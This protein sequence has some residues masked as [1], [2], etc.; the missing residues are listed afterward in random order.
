MPQPQEVEEWFDVRDNISLL[1][2]T[3]CFELFAKHARKP[4]DLRCEFWML[5]TSKQKRVHCYSQKDCIG[6]LEKRWAEVDEINFYQ[7]AGPLRYAQIAGRRHYF[8]FRAEEL[9]FEEIER[10]FTSTF[11]LDQSRPQPYKYRSSSIEFDIGHWSPRLF[12][13]GLSKI[14]ELVGPHP[15]LERA[16]YKT[17]EGDIEKLTPF[18]DIDE[19]LR[20]IDTGVSAFGEISLQLAARST[21]IGITVPSD[22]KKLRIRTSIA[23]KDLDPVLEAWPPELKLRQVKAVDTGDLFSGSGSS[24]KQESNW[25][26]LGVPVAT[27]FITAMSVTGV[28]GIKKA[29]WPDYKLV[30]TSP[31][32]EGGKAAWSAK[33]IVLDWHLQ[34]E[35]PSLRS[36]QKD[37]QATVRIIG[38]NAQPYEVRGSPPLSVG[39]NPGEHIVSID[40]SDLPPM[41]F[42]LN[43]GDSQTP[44]AS[45]PTKK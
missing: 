27:A 32:V 23:P 20:A 1:W 3:K 40:V 37:V 9:S 5:S 41:S 16:F 42:R 13:A 44:P 43:V 31:I 39:V 36:I 19:F 28:V 26:K 21:T 34:P 25:V 10:D 12:A 22:H 17:Y 45:A 14:V 29:I 7:F 6:F 30:I 35:Q 8:R 4:D 11:A 15:H 2:L 24:T 33:K 18:F 38:L